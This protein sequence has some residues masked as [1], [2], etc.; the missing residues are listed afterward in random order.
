MPLPEEL[1]VSR[2]IRVGIGDYA[3]GGPEASYRVTLGSC[4]GVALVWSRQ[5]RFGVAHVLLPSARKGSLHSQASRYADSVVPFL[6]SELGV[7]GR[8]REITAFV[9]GGGRMYEQGSDN[10]QVGSLNVA[11]LNCALKEHRI[12]IEASDFGGITPRQLVVDG[13][14]RQVYSMHLDD[15]SG[16][17]SWNL[18]RRFCTPESL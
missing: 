7:E 15:P 14:S 1:A 2:A 4:V 18:P 16:S 3:M 9:A 11:A 12:R 13:P 6:L 8:N 17:L 5:S 10:E